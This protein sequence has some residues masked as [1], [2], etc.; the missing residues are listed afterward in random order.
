M[1]IKKE[2]AVSKVFYLTLRREDTKKNKIEVK[3]LR[4]GDLVA[5]FLKLIFEAASLKI[6]FRYIIDLVL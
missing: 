5:N 6:T 3:A 1:K 2:E 4:L